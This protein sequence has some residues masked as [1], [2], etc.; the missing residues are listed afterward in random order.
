M[1]KHNNLIN[2]TIANSFS[3]SNKKS[4]QIKTKKQ[5]HTNLKY[6]HGYL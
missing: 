3:D 2:N 5:F 4:L 6:K 1:L